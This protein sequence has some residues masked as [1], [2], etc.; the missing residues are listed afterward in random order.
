MIWVAIKA[1]QS[2]ERGKPAGS[3]VSG[4][5][6][7]HRDRQATDVAAAKA[8]PMRQ[9]VELQARPRVNSKKAKYEFAA[10]ESRHCSLAANE[11]DILAEELRVPKFGS[12]Q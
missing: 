1:K 2:Q 8:I 6:I 3:V 12:S 5:G 7:A 10:T 9:H 11:K 4:G